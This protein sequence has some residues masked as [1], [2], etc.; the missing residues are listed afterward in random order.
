VYIYIHTY[1][2]IRICLCTYIHTHTYIYIFIYVH[3]RWEHTAGH[4]SESLAKIARSTHDTIRGLIWRGKKKEKQNI[5][6]YSNPRTAHTSLS[7]LDLAENHT[8]KR[9]EANKICIFKITHITYD[10][11]RVFCGDMYMCSWV[12]SH[13]EKNISMTVFV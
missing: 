3:Y 6:T 12:V 10:A 7:V 11:L 1:I 2:C 13:T 4:N 9:G 8:Q 5:Y